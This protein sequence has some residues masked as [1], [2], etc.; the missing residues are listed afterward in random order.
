[1]LIRM[2]IHHEVLTFSNKANCTEQKLT[3]LKGEIDSCTITKALI[4]FSVIARTLKQKIN[5]K[6]SGLDQHYKSTNSQTPN[7]LWGHNE[8]DMTKHST[9]HILLIN[10]RTYILFKCTWDI[11]QDI[12]YIR[13]Q[14]K[15]DIFLKIEIIQRTTE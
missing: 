10:S 6:N 4:Q 13:P 2:T 5:K 11:L 3:E 7:S 15:S 9:Y 14:G 1:M 8:V 12:P